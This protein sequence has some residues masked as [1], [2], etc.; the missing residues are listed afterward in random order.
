M[1]RSGGG[2]LQRAATVVSTQPPWYNVMMCGQVGHQGGPGASLPGLSGRVPHPAR[3]QHRV[4]G[5]QDRDRA[6]D[7]QRGRD[8][9][10]EAG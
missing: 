1:A 8:D 9:Q 4:G 5:Q 7:L 10:G 3:V 6:D 2:L